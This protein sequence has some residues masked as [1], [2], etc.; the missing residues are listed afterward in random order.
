M[1]K[2]YIFLFTVLFFVLSV[3]TRSF[4]SNAGDVTSYMPA[5]VKSLIDGIFS[6]N[7]TKRAE[8]AFKLGNLGEKASQATPFLLRMLDDNLPVWCRYNGQGTWTTPGKEA[9][10]ALVEIGK[11]SLQYIL[12]LLENDHPY[13]SMNEYMER[14]LV[15][16]LTRISGL[17]YGNDFGKWINWLKTQQ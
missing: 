7:A 13:I 3:S 12:P 2:I 1:R 4:T 15:Y 17:K 6:V 5:E 9:A 11:P 14:N 10:K 8:A 16:A